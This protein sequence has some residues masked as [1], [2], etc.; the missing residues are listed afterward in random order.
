M[1]LEA[2]FDIFEHL[3]QCCRLSQ[4]YRECIK[5]IPDESLLSVAEYSWNLVNL[6]PND[7]ELCI[8]SS[9]LIMSCQ[10]NS[11]RSTSLTV[12]CSAPSN[13]LWYLSRQEN[14][15]HPKWLCLEACH[16]WS[17]EVRCVHSALKQNTHR[18]IALERGLCFFGEALPSL[19]ACCIA[20][21]VVGNGGIC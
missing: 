1:A 11:L 15:L 3:Q 2:S 12:V 7:I 19:A 17:N 8:Q 6:E 21:L 4:S 14:L 18:N 5:R 9:S 10:L 16:P 20:H 13:W